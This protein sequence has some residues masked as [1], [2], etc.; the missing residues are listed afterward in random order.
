MKKQESAT[1][2]LKRVKLLP[3]ED[4]MKI[5]EAVY[6]HKGLHNKL[7]R[8]ICQQYEELKPQTQYRSSKQDLLKIPIHKT[9][10]FKSSNIYRTVQTWNSIPFSIK[11][12]ENSSTFKIN[13]QKYLQKTFAP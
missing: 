1:D 12:I 7:P 10:K 5:H 4:K 6:I 2:A 8:S 13:Y 3:L 9:E 11:Q